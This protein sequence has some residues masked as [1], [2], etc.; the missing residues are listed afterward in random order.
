[1]AKLAAAAALLTA[2]PAALAFSSN[3]APGAVPATQAPNYN[4]N[5]NLPDLWNATV[6]GARSQQQPERSAEFHLVL[7]AKVMGCVR[8]N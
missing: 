1:M 2:V 8:E 4:F 7:Q 5:P 3:P 6:S